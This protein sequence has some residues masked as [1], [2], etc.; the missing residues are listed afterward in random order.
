[1]KYLVWLFFCLLFGCQNNTTK[2]SD[3]IKNDTLNT[4]KTHEH[5]LILE[6]HLVTSP[7]GLFVRSKASFK[8]DK[9]N[10]LSYRTEVEIIKKTKIFDTINDDGFNIVGEWIEIKNDT[11]SDK[12][13]VFGAY[14]KTT[15]QIKKICERPM[16]VSKEKKWS[17]FY[18]IYQFSDDIIGIAMLEGDDNNSEQRLNFEKIDKNYL[19]ELIGNKPKHSLYKDTF[20]HLF[21]NKDVTSKY[22]S[23]V[24]SSFYVY[25]TKKVVEV[26]IQDVLFH[27]NE[28]STPF[29]MLK[30]NSKVFDAAITGIPLFASKR[31]LKNIEFDSFKKV[32]SYFNYNIDICNL[33]AD[34]QFGNDNGHINLFLKHENYYFGYRNDNDYNDNNLV[35]PYRYIISI[36]D[37]TIKYHLSSH[38]DLFGCPCL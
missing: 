17:D 28:C 26:K 10:K 36:K 5:K 16:Y 1:M 6:K 20:V 4:E 35:E 9:L 2:K 7:N 33:W 23:L 11:I 25:C 38:L 29:V 32:K 22:N 27:A 3:N 34:C 12:S 31:E 18:G 24:D 15:N 14:L 21:K 8:G 19:N 13:F 30:L 37:D